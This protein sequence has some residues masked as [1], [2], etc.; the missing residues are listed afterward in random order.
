MLRALQRTVNT[1]Q[2]IIVIIIRMDNI[3][4]HSAD[5]VGT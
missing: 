1:Y 5:L 3:E 2:M 4:S